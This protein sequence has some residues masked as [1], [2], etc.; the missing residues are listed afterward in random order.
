MFYDDSTKKKNILILAK[1]Y[2]KNKTNAS[3]ASIERMRCRLC[4]HSQCL[5]MRAILLIRPYMTLSWVGFGFFFA[6]TILLCQAEYFI[7]ESTLSSVFGSLHSDSCSDLVLL[8][9]QLHSRHTSH[10]QTWTHM[11]FFPIATPLHGIL[12]PAAIISRTCFR[13]LQSIFRFVQPSKV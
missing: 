2:E 12:S 4:S 7:F 3:P 1:E 13:V 9:S 6:S 5:L 10:V 8:P 11:V